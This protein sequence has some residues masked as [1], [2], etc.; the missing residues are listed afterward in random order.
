MRLHELGLDLLQLGG[1]RIAQVGHGHR[2][3]THHSRAEP[4][5]AAGHPR[6][7]DLR[8][9]V[10]P[11]VSWLGRVIRAK[12]LLRWLVLGGLCLFGISVAWD[13]MP[14]YRENNIIDRAG[15]GPF[16]VHGGLDRVVAGLDRSTGIFWLSMA[17]VA[18]VG[19]MAMLAAVP[20]APRSGWGV[21]GA[22]GRHLVSH[23]R[24]TGRESA[25][26]GCRL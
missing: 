15:I 2:P 21:Q 22:N 17:F 1:L 6:T 14:P 25:V 18:S 5:H 7:H 24:P 26:A 11:W 3:H 16:T 4:V 20:H 12:G 23:M 19:I 8:L 13:W 10:T 9:V